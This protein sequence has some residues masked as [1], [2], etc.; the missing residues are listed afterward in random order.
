MRISNVNKIGT[1]VIDKITSL[2]YEITEVNG[3]GSELEAIAARVN[4]DNEVDPSLG[5]IRIT[6][7][8]DICFRAVKFI[9]DE[10]IYSEFMVIDGKLVRG[11]S[12]IETGNIKPVRIVG[13][14]PGKIVLAAEINGEA[15]LV[16]YEVLR[17]RF[18]EL[19]VMPLDAVNIIDRDEYKLYIKR[20]TRTEEKED[21]STEEVF[22]STA[23]YY[24]S[25]DS[26]SVEY[27]DEELFVYD[28]KVVLTDIKTDAVETTGHVLKGKDNNTY[29]QIVIRYGDFEV[30]LNYYP[31]DP[32]EA[33]YSNFFKTYV[34]TGRDYLRLRGNRV[35]DINS[36]KVSEAKGYRYLADISS[37]GDSTVIVLANDEYAVK[38][39]TVTGTS[40][41]GD[42]VTVA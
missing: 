2:K 12:M 15:K 41:R 38:T 39:I 17:D 20:L 40:D 27:I 24:I 18:E 9:P 14:F 10:T 31:C 35:L 29:I 19:I 30:L 33:T 22:D 11:D 13:K 26:T 16:S 21:G 5:K 36:D 1:Q 37:K 8:N 42:I 6:P 25:K 28:R 34:I 32:S 23:I 3:S 7:K 4:D